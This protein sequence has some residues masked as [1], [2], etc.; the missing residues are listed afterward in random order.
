MRRQATARKDLLIP[1]SFQKEDS[2]MLAQM[3][4]PNVNQQRKR[5]N[6]VG[7]YELQVSERQV[8]AKNGCEPPAPTIRRLGESGAQQK[9]PK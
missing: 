8:I 5:H 4:S 9:I 2:A 3:R 7:H 6:A 1:G